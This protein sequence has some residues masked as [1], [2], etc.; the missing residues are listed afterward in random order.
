LVG[1][2]I[3]SLHSHLGWLE[4]IEG[5]TW[6]GIEK[7][8]VK[9]PLIADI[10]MEV[11]KAY[12]MLQGESDTHAVRA[13]FFV[14]PNGIIKTILYYPASLGRNFAEIKRVYDEDKYIDDPHTAVASAVYEA[15]VQKTDDHT[16]TVIASTASPYKFPRVAV[17]AV[18]GKDSGDDFKAVE[19]LHQLSGVA[20]PAAVDGLEHAEVRHKTVVAAADMQKAVESYL[21]V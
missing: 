11:A 6:D 4:A 14:D 12:G 20:I 5:Y 2:S 19:D 16:P 3:D 17:S 18:T 13:V 9:F 15:Y 1:L 21:G 8:K 10:R 7:P